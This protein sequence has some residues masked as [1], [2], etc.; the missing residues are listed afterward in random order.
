VFWRGDPKTRAA[1][2]TSDN[3]PRNGAILK[4]TGPYRVGGED[5]MLVKEIQQAGTQGFKPVPP[6]TWMMYTQGGPLLRDI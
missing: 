6:G 3:W 2:P 4:G 1:A 5:W